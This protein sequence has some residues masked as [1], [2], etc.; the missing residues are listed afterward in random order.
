MSRI[1]TSAM[2]FFFYVFFDHVYYLK[3]HFVLQSFSLLFIQC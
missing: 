2:V 1:L 3:P